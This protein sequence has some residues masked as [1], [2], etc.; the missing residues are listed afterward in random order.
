MFTPRYDSTDL[1]KVADLARFPELMWLHKYQMV[2]GITVAALCSLLAGWSGLVVGFLWSTVLVFHA[3]FCINSLA[4][5][6]GEQ[7]HVTGDDSRNNWFLAFF[8]MGKAGT[9]TITPTKAACVKASN[10]GRSTQLIAF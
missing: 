1:V 6:H 4:H 10:G 2:P 7:R 8:T 9:T 3:V 5:L